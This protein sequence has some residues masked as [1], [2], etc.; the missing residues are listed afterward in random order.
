MTY[1][2]VDHAVELAGSVAALQLGYQIVRR[3]GELTTGGL[4]TPTAM[5]PIPA[6]DLVAGEKTVRGSY[7][8]S[9][10]PARDIPRYVRLFQ[11]GQLPVDRLLSRT[12]PMTAINEG[13]DLLREGKILRGVVLPNA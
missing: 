7:L 9:C 13:F 3:G 10:V 4:P 12:M 8:G 5:L 1:G 2:G 11:S 6:V